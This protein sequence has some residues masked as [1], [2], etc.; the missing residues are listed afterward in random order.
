MTYQR[1]LILFFSLF[2]FRCSADAGA[3]TLD[4]PMPIHQPKGP[5]VYAVPPTTGEWSGN[6][7]LGM[8]REFAPD[9]NNRQ[10][11]LYMPEWG[12]PE[13]WTITLGVEYPAN[14]PSRFEVVATIEV[15]VGGATQTFELDWIDGQAVTVTANSIKV[16]AQWF[17]APGGAPKVFLTTTVARGESGN[18]HAPIKCKN[19][20][21][22]VADGNDSSIVQI[23][24]FA[25]RVRLAPNIS[26]NGAIYS[27]LSFIQF[28]GDAA[29]LNGAGVTF[30]SELGGAAYAAG[31]P[32]P[33]LA[34]FVQYHN[35][36][37]A[38]QAGIWIFDIEP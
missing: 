38:S 19:F 29:G 35:G 5:R 26:T 32:I 17:T 11:I 37:G 25:R 6:N 10:D 14:L 36:S 31:V 9:A 30:G 2:L 8:K 16:T 23:P 22:A 33:Q 12:P 27:P 3:Q 20:G 24:A 21:L 7:N 18:A 13:R 1:F 15:G 28:W 4:D 34:K